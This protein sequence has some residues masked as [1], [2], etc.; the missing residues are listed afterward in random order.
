MPELLWGVKVYEI[1]QLN[2]F[3][4]RLANTLIEVQITDIFS[5][6]TML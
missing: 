4:C 6:E 1:R 3:Y 2:L 5:L